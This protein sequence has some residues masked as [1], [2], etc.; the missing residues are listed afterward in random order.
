MKNFTL[1]LF[2]FCSAWQYV[3][4]QSETSVLKFG[5]SGLIDRELQFEYERALKGGSSFQVELLAG[6]PRRI[7][8]IYTSPFSSVGTSDQYNMDF[9]TSTMLTFAVIPEYRLYPLRRSALRG[10]YVG[11]YLKAKMRMM[12]ARDTYKNYQMYPTATSKTT[13]FTI[14]GGLGIGYQLI[15][16]RFTL[17]IGAGLGID[18]HMISGKFTSSDAGEDYEGWQPYVDA[19]LSNI[20]V[21]GEDLETTVEG[22]AISMKG[23]TPFIGIRPVISLG[24]AFQ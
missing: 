23:N 16:G 6:I 7:P 12:S 17:D 1:L 2:F 9:D 13:V 3:S 21:F 11:P 14:G 4:A 5:V 10:F 18:Y 8:Q 20:P 15:L 19:A 24:Y 22:S